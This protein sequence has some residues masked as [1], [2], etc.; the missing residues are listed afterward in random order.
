M[1]N[2]TVEQVKVVQAIK[3]CDGRGI[4]AIATGVGKTK[5]TIDY[6][7]DEPTIIDIL[8]V[9]PTRELRDNEVLNEFKKWGT[10]NDINL[11]LTCYNSLKKLSGKTY[12][13]IVLDEGHEL[14]PAREEALNQISFNKLLMLSA[15]LPHELDKK[16]IMSNL[17]LNVIYEITLEDALEKALVSNF[18]IEVIKISLSKSKNLEVKYKKGGKDLS[19]LTSEYERYMYYTDIIE[20]RTRMGLPVNKFTRFNR[21]RVIYNLPSKTAL[22]KSILKK[23]GKNKR[24]LVFGASIEQ[25]EKICK[26]TYHSKRN[27]DDLKLFKENKIK[28]LGVVNA[29]NQ[30][31]NV[32]VID[33]ILAVQLNSNPRHL[34]QR[35]GRGIRF[36]PGHTCKIIILVAEDCVDEEWCNVV[37]SNINKT[38]ICQKS[39][40]PFPN[41]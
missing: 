38:L 2:R 39:I 31:S 24:V 7:N 4:L 15:T 18:E 37:L 36:K 32:G 11:E 30:G 21:M 26:H 27:S 5:I 13:L 1:D 20:S 14:T 3:D 28:E 33:Y 34:I 12:D 16:I 29:L 19:F 35:L 41:V 6:I 22:A 25:I 23:I 10:R 17:K 9:V 8:W 40:N